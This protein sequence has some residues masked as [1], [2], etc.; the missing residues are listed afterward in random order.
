[1]QR[2]TTLH[3]AK[4]NSIDDAGG[5]FVGTDVESALQEL[6]GSLRI[7]GYQIAV[8]VSTGN[9]TVAIKNESGSDPSSSEPVRII[10]GGI[11]REITSALSVTLNAGANTFNAGS[12][13]LATYLINYFVYLG[14]N[15]TDGVVIGFSRI[16]YAL[17]YGDFS[18]TATNEKYAKI[19]T[20]TNAVS[21]DNYENIGRFSATLSA[22]AGYTWSISG[23]GDPINK[24]F[25]ISD[26]LTY[27]PQGT[28]S[29]SMTWSLTSIV[30]QQY[31]I[32]NQ[33][34]Y[35][36]V[37][38]YGTTGGTASNELHLSLPFSGQGTIGYGMAARVRDATS[39]VV[40]LANGGV[41]TT[42]AYLIKT[43]NTNF[44][45]GTGRGGW[46]TGYYSIV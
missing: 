31:K 30:Y 42:Y 5:Y 17:N 46:V 45:L 26:T 12:T 8:S 21:T 19:S 16:P 20:I 37:G 28:A 22:G 1:M 15:A 14:Y 32:I 7:T 35:L 39:G 27:N 29:G 41:Y 3:H 11:T 43:D 40:P 36:V 4:D 10:I 33:E 44:G 34:V 24:P 9:I 6:A 2:V 25:F 18:A 38:A 23:T 13:E